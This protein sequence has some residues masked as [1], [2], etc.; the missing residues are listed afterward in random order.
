MTE[1]VNPDPGFWT[2]TALI[3]LGYG[4]WVSMTMVA[5][6]LAM[7][8]PAVTIPQLN[9]KNSDIKITTSDEGWIGQCVLKVLD[10]FFIT[11]LFLLADSHAWYSVFLI[12]L[13]SICLI[14]LNTQ[15]QVV[16]AVE[17]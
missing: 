4:V 10:H 1:I 17:A 7:G 16:L 9:D 13:S 6:G 12:S 3:Q 14:S 5:V 2:K 11:N 15:N 8:F